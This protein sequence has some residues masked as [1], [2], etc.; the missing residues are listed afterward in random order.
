MTP[1]PRALLA[2]GAAALGFPLGEEQLDGFDRYGELL[3]SARDELNLTALSDPL[4]IA[5]KH[6]LDSLTVLPALP[7]GPLHLID[8]GTGAGFPGLALKIA[9][10]ELRVVLLEATGKKVVWLQR[11]VAALGLQGVSA[12][13]DRAETL[14]HVPEHRGAYDVAVAR[15]V[16]PLAVLCELCLPFLK[17]GGRFIAQKTSSGA[18]SEVPAAAGALRTLG[19]RLLG[20]QPVA[21][22]RLPNRVLVLVEQTRP[23]L[24]TYPRRPGLPSKRPL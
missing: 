1:D 13:A 17:P 21:V 20:V 22:E 23:A 14:G 24:A 7:L 3:R 8:V 16:A 6:F 18:E 2:A 11:V 19:G 12:I 10:P 9:R 4:D 15:A 5:E